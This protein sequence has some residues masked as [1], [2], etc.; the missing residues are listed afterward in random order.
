MEE[1][2]LRCGLRFEIDS[3]A[4]RGLSAIK[5]GRYIET[6][7]AVKHTFAD[8]FTVNGMFAAGPN[9]GIRGALLR[10]WGLM[11]LAVPLFAQQL[12]DSSGG[13]LTEEHHHPVPGQQVAYL[14]SAPMKI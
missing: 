8:R 6:G 7:R 2:A 13:R 3:H 5:A 12:P 10:M 4:I 9:G 14:G 1:Q 11:L